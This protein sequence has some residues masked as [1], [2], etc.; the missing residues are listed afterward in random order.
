MIKAFLLDVN[1]KD[2]YKLSSMLQQSGRVHVIGMS[3][4]PGDAVETL[5]R[6]QPD[7]LFLELQLPDLQGVLV[8]EQ[9][10][11]KL[12]QIQI[13]VV[14]GSKQHALWAFDQAVADY[15]LKPLEELRLGQSLDRLRLGS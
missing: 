3:T 6:L 11:R 5:L 9:V 7:V 8:A 10:K 4:H 15:V 14:T 13:I 12:P 1:Q 2:L